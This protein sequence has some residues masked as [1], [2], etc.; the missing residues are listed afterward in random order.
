MLDNSR[1]SKNCKIGNGTRHFLFFKNY[2]EIYHSDWYSLSCVSFEFPPVIYILSRSLGQ[3]LTRH[4]KLIYISHSP[5]SKSWTFREGERER[6]REIALCWAMCWDLCLWS[7]WSGNKKKSLSPR[8]ILSP[9]LEIIQDTPMWATPKTLNW[10][11]QG[12][13]INFRTL[14]PP[15]CFDVSQVYFANVLYSSTHLERYTMLCMLCTQL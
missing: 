5:N 3:K 11:K 2:I 6:E 12:W 14:W 9:R 8:K 10:G 4:I 15:L 13:Q 1:I 7:G